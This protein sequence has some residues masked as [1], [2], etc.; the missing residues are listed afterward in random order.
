MQRPA[1]FG[2]MWSMVTR[3]PSHLDRLSEVARTRGWLVRVRE[4]SKEDLDSLFG[5]QD[6]WDLTAFCGEFRL[7][8]S[9]EVDARGKRL[10]FRWGSLA[11]RP[12]G[13]D[14][15]V[16]VRHSLGIKT[17]VES[18]CVDLKAAE[19][20]LENVAK[21]ERRFEAWCEMNR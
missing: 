16:W 19:W 18:I 7:Y 17:R 2:P 15:E 21:I 5:M 14:E 4:V 6:G 10:R 8:L 1:P 9:F 20:L 13:L 12:P 3:A 11:K